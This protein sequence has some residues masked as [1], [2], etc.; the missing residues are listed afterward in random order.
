MTAINALFSHMLDLKHIFNFSQASLIKSINCKNSRR[1]LESAVISRSKHIKQRLG[2]Y[3]IS[4]YLADIILREN[5]TEVEN[6]LE[7][8][9]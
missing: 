8:F 6:G 2:F 9:L 4:P 1:Q 5:N 7:K 3:Q